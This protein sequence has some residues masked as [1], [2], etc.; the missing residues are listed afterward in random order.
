MNQ[1]STFP[2]DEEL[3]AY[4][5]GE[6]SGESA[7]HLE[8]LVAT[9]THVAARLEFLTRGTDLPL[10]AAFAPLLDAA[11]KVRLEALLSNIPALRAVSE[12]GVSSPGRRGFLAA[13]AASLVAGVFLDR[14][15]VELGHRTVPEDESSH[16]RGVVAQY[17]ALYTSDTLAGPMP[18]RQVEESQLARLEQ[19]LGLSLSPEA[20]SL[21]DVDFR[22]AQ[23]L[24][25]DDRSLGQIAYLD[26][27]TGPLALCIVRSDGPP[28]GPDIETRKGMNIVFWSTATHSYMLVGHASVERMS[29]L[30]NDVAARL[31]A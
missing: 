30:A 10:E 20:V 2:S 3:T 14:G 31:T 25:Y 5:D 8:M 21:P 22:H 13:I 15:L 29:A 24:R 19:Q 7:H 27:A 1:E 11:P 4:L 16:W 18:T 28:A 17:I 9:D 6:L 12:A 23:L 26:P